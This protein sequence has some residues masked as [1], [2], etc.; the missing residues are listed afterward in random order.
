MFR[1]KYVRL[2]ILALLIGLIVALL[3]LCIPAVFGSLINSIVDTFPF[4]GFLLTLTSPAAAF[5]VGGLFSVGI[6]IVG[7]VGI[8]IYTTIRN[9]LIDKQAHTV[10]KEIAPI[11]AKISHD[12]EELREQIP[13][14]SIQKEL[15]QT[16]PPIKHSG[17][18]KNWRCTML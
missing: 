8:A 6:F 3:C 14:P 11:L 1:N 9:R 10:S 15:F 17:S 5:V 7:C 4:M 16:V 18:K 12:V 13:A 2:F